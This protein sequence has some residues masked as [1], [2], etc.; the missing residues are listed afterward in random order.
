MKQQYTPMKYCPSNGTAYYCPP[1]YAEDFRKQYPNIFWDFNPWTGQARNVLDRESD[2]FGLLII[3]PGEATQALIR[4]LKVQLQPTKKGKFI[5]L[6]GID[7]SGTSTQADLLTKYLIGQEVTTHQTFEPSTGPI[8]TMI[9]QILFGRITISKE[10][11][12]FRKGS[13]LFDTQ[14]AHLY[15]ADRHDHL[16]NDVDGVM[17]SLAAGKTVIC[18]RY[19]F[20]S[21]AYHCNTERD[22]EFVTNLNAEFPQPDLVIYLNHTV[23]ASLERMSGRIV[24]DAHENEGKLTVTKK[25]YDQVFTDYEGE[26]FIVDATL[27][28][29]V[30]HTLIVDEINKLLF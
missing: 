13:N 27:P 14:M 1:V 16:Y 20:S 10:E 9:R 8:G 17:K 22:W 15:A 11:N 12:P 2:C 29:A 25:N 6:E 5:V 4:N 18:T 23:E 28:I 24:K 30:V 19:Y 26:L 3:P 21:L 7:G